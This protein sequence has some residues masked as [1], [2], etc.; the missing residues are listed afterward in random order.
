MNPFLLWD[1]LGY[2]TKS[3]I[4]CPMTDPQLLVLEGTTI[5][6]KHF[7]FFLVSTLIKAPFLQQEPAK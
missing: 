6:N 2:S 5:R 4:H 3:S 7:N 1:Y